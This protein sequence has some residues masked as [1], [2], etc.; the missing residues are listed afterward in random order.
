ML[1]GL[2]SKSAPMPRDDS[3]RWM[4]ARR[5]LRSRLKSIPGSSAVPSRPRRLLSLRFIVLA[6]IRREVEAGQSVVGKHH[7]RF[8]YPLACGSFLLIFAH[9]AFGFVSRLWSSLV[10]IIWE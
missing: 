3:S 9:C 2:V 6:A 10:I 4:R 7:T 1:T 5:S 8:D